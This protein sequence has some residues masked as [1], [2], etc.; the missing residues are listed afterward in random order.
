MGHGLH[1]T[2]ITC[3]DTVS[4]SAHLRMAN[5]TPFESITRQTLIAFRDQNAAF[6]RRAEF[7]VAARE[8]VGGHGP[9]L[10]GLPAYDPVA[11]G[12]SRGPSRV[13]M[14]SPACAGR[15]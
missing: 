8:F 4:V 6:F 1:A 3:A 2:G 9:L 7:G 12:R 11:V 5:S 10:A 15:A 14:V 13:S